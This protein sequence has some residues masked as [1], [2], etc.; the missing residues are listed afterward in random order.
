MGCENP[1]SKEDLDII[2]TKG[3]IGDLRITKISLPE[4]INKGYN[5]ITP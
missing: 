2:L 4:I 1:T 5:Y 3:T